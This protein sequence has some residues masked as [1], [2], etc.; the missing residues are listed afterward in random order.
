[1]AVSF[2]YETILWCNVH[3]YQVQIVAIGLYLR[4][5][6]RLNLYETVLSRCVQ[7][8]IY[9]GNSLFFSA[10]ELL[11]APGSVH[12]LVTTLIDGRL[13]RVYKNLW[14]SLREFWLSAVSQYSGDTYIVYEDQRL[15]YSQVH[16]RAT[17]VA[18]LF[19]NVY[20]IKKGDRVAICS[21]NCPEYLVIFWACHLIG[22]VSVLANAWLPLKPLSHCLALTECKLVVV[23]PERADLIRPAVWQIFRDTEIK[24]FLV[25]DLREGKNCWEGMKSF[26]ESLDEYQND[27]KEIIKSPV[28]IHPEDN[29]TLIFTSGTTGLPKGV[30]S[31][32]RQFMTNV[33]N[34]LAGG[35]RAALRRGED[36]PTT[37]RTGPQ[38]AT[39]IAVPLFHVTGST[40]FSMMATMTGMKVVM[41]KKWEVE[42][43]TLSCTRLIKREGV[44]IAGGVPAMVTDLTLSSLV[45]HPLEG[46]L[47]GG[48]PAPD[49]LVPRARKAFPTATMIQAY[50]LTETNS[51]AVSFA[52]E[53]YIA[54]PTSTGR[55]C[56]V[57]DI[58]IVHENTCLPP[59]VVGEVWLRG[60]N[61]MKCYWGD[62]KAT[63]DTITKDGWLKTGDL[64]YLDDEGF[65]YVKDRIKDIIIRG[66]E[67]IDSVT[68]E[69]ALYADPRVLEAAAVG[70]PDERLGELVAAIVSVRPAYDGQVTESML[71]EQARSRLP[72]FAVPVMII[73]LNRTFE[74]TPSGKIMKGDLRKIARSQWEMRR[75]GG[76]GEVGREPRV[77]L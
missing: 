37:Q 58:K 35:F 52:G 47:F 66:G 13:Q 73:I 19:R 31:T 42:E 32:Q 53:D 75:R 43:G 50:G 4:N 14:P 51:I 24:N 70:V 34:V 11:T 18:A 45:G 5:T 28:S 63:D 25:L 76:S 38:K 30:L 72:K 26:Q 39:L 57:N 20:N 64:G 3:Q 29:A 69:N 60:P 55:A 59:G 23:D 17:K 46:L 71:I 40:S 21:R 1:M 36:F 61:I 2:L 27:G 6:R 7:N 77:N 54:R 33:L 9:H 74:H 48:S 68:V 65:L 8:V 41:M 44:A 15:T 10:E 49:T 12:E 62:P 67:N 22:A 56:P 16:D